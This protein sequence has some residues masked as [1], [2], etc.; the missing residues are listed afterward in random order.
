MDEFNNEKSRE[1]AVSTGSSTLFLVIGW[2][3]A[4]LSL[5]AYPFV[6]GTVG[7]IMG[8]LST[9]SQSRAGLPLIISSIVLMGIGLIY[10]GVIMNYV[11]HYMGM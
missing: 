6:F 4:I 9:K 5:L 11:R 8:V 2:I 1:E 7:V 10:S 3:A